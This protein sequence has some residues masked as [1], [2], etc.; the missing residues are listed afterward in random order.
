M[1]K[2]IK[3][4]VIYIVICSFVIPANSQTTI[5]LNLQVALNEAHTVATSAMLEEYEET[6]RQ[7]VRQSLSVTAT[8]TYSVR[9]TTFM[10]EV[11]FNNGKGILLSGNKNCLP[12]LG[13]L[14]NTEMSVFDTNAPCCL[15][16]LLEGYVEQVRASFV[17]GRSNSENAEKWDNLLAG[18]I[19]RNRA[20]IVVEPLTTSKWGQS[21]SNDGQCEA[22]NYYIADKNCNKCG[23][24]SKKPPAGCGAVAMAQ[25]MYYWKYPVS[26]G[27]AEYDWCNMSDELRSSSSNYISERNAVAYLIKDCASA[28]ITIYGCNGSSSISTQIAL[29]LNRRGYTHALQ[30][31]DPQI[32]IGRIKRNLDN[33]R[34]LIIG[35]GGNGGGHF[36]VCDGYDS[37]D[38]FHFNWGWPG[39]WNNSA[40]MYQDDIWFTMDNIYDNDGTYPNGLKDYIYAIYPSGNFDYCD[41]NVTLTNA[42]QDI[43]KYPT[44]LTVDFGN[45]TD[46]TIA[47]GQNVTYVAHNSIV[48]K[49]GFKAEAGSHFV[50]RIEPCNNCNSVK[51]AV[52]SL[53]NGVEVE[54][55]LYIA[56]GDNEEE[57]PMGES[58]TIS[59]EPQIYPNPTTGLLTIITTN[60][61]SRIQTIELYNTQGAKQF[62]FNGNHGS[63]QEIDISHLPSQM[64]VLK[65]YVNGQVFTKKLILQK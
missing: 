14:G 52:K 62:T 25:V 60:G 8:N 48:I 64:Y 22:Y 61:N 47:S 58:K 35:L 15:T 20:N 38:Y 39:Y 28:I 55:E 44:N 63:F 18:S 59:E 30:L 32:W 50:A 7:N 54:E 9:D 19:N 6:E 57:Q 16:A 27:S 49:P 17:D 33:G 24:T 10:Y 31:V 3:N 23:G 40:G 56:V 51:V 37:D 41:Y 53:K 1:K 29:A 36:V 2:Y 43:P 4:L 34:P 12:V 65:V 5:S 42:S 21:S 13:Y 46:N 45:T 11:F 26:H